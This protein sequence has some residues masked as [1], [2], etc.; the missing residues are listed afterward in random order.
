MSEIIKYPYKQLHGH[1]EKR[2]TISQIAYHTNFPKC[3]YF[4]MT[5]FPFVK[6]FLHAHKYMSEYIFIYETIYIDMSV[7]K[8]ATVVLLG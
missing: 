8:A 4:H 6:A 3:S 1:S 2:G 7:S 5:S